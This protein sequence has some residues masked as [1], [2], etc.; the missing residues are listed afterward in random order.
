MVAEL[1]AA[2]LLPALSVALLAAMLMARV[3]SP[4]IPLMVTV[5]VLPVPLKARVPLASP[6]LFKVI[7][8]RTRVMLSALA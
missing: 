8:P 7:L 2:A 3:P 6:V 1:A 4:L 5:R